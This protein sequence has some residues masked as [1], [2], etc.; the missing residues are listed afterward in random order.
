M[1]QPKG[2]VFDKD[3]TLFDFAK[4]WER[5]AERFL[6]RLSESPEDARRL[7]EAIGFDTRRLCFERHSVVIAG[8]PGEVAST[9]SPRLP[10]WSQAQ[11]IDVMNEEAAAAQQIEAVPLN[12]LMHRLKQAGTVLGVVTND[13][14]APA[15]A[16]LEA[17]GIREH[18]A[19]VAG[20]DSGFGA[21]PDAGQLIAFMDHVGL[22]P[23]ECLMVGDSTH[24]LIAGR[25]AEMSCVGVLTGLAPRETLL[26][27][28][29]A[30]LPDIG[31]LPDW[32]AR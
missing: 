26:P 28:A 11:I 20:F 14:E 17:A 3:G 12:P 30:V 6:A 1:T 27:L 13:A 15:L 32:L 25:K 16:H 4:S 23:S 31:H 24:D 10:G 29:D 2:I 18:F 7:G 8:T 22:P 19:F 21:K 5:W 9:L